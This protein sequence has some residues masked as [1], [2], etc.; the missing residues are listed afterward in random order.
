MTMIDPG[1]F[2]TSHAYN[3]LGCLFFF[4]TWLFILVS[5]VCK[6]I[7]LGLKTMQNIIIVTS[8]CDINYTLSILYA[9]SSHLKMLFMTHSR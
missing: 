7:A 5:S 2:F 1:F 6:E 8:F 9:M 3:N 4:I